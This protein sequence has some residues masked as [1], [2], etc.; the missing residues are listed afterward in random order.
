MLSM[1]AAGLW[2]SAHVARADGVVPPPTDLPD[3]LTL[4]EAVRIFRSRG[5][6][7][8]IAQ[9]AVKNAE[10]QVGIAGAVPNPVV[11]GA[12]GRVFDYDTTGC[13]GCSND[14]WAVGISD[15]AAI[16][17][18]LSGK[19][20]LRL[21]VARNA[22]AAAKL[23]RVDAERTIAFQVKS[24]YLQA[25]QATLGYKFAKE[26]ASTNAR[27]LDLFQTRYRTGAINEG[28]VARIQTQKLES[29]QA[30]DQA[31]LTLRQARVALAFLIGVRGRVPDFEVEVKTLDYAEPRPLTGASEEGLL[32]MAFEHRPDLVAAGYQ[33]ASA[34]AA[35]ALAKR[36]RFPDISFAVNYSQIGTSAN[37]G[38]GALQPPLLTFG[39][40]GPLPVFYQLQGEQR[41][42]EA[43]YESNSLT[44]AKTTAQ[45]VDDVAAGYSGYT[46]SQ[47]LVQRMEAG[48]LLA[49][50]KTARDITR[51]Q[52]EKGAASLT[53]FL[54]AQRTY[55]AT[56]VEYF[57]DL[58][59]YW[60]AVFQLEQ[61]VG[62]E[63]H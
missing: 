45:V 24:A 3:T 13:Q 32:R 35:I 58:T 12:W 43:Q 33:R 56:N 46:T 37:Q 18:S 21:K 57:A 44:Q 41:Q 36:N 10:G 20:D 63:L 51:L 11:N 16:E 48:G 40:T 39:I 61:A 54:D 22:L 60:T 49:S 62:V 8:L 52:Y 19:R 28:D 30:L 38:G 5:L 42:A 17:D 14:Y 53:D 34:E 2:L 31:A 26:V 59:N 9:A 50:A 29:D 25:A 1:W 55:I 27:T 15:S 7:L 6:D 4:D 23:S 47:K